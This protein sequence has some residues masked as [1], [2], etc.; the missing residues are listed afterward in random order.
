MKKLFKQITCFMLALL[1]FAGVAIAHPAPVK[2]A[3]DDDYINL[4]GLPL[5]LETST[6]GVARA[7][8][9]TTRST[10]PLYIDLYFAEP[11]SFSYE[12]KS[13][14]GTVVD[15]DTIIDTDEYW[16]SIT[17]ETTTTWV[18]EL[19]YKSAAVGTFSFD[20]T[21][22]TD[23]SY[24]LVIDQ[25][26][27]PAAT[28]SH[29]QMTITA[30]FTDKLKVENASGKVTWTSSNKSIA[31]VNDKGV[32]TAKK[33][34]RCT[35]TA[36]TEDGSKLKCV[37]KVA[38]NVYTRT[39][40]TNADADK[41]E[42]TAYIYKASTDASGNLVC[43]FR[44]IN[45]TSRSITKLSDMR[46]DVK[47]ANKKTLFSYKVKSKTVSVTGYRYKDYSI[48]IPKSVVKKCNL[49]T[50]TISFTGDYIYTL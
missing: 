44:V 31:T 39:K 35:V 20:V 19:P 24:A 17:G 6:A 5:T 12:L 2:A 27:T 3:E 40:G 28:I 32:V 22:M 48:T 36:T 14:S 42:V 33:K 18:Y 38:N 15:S 7:H 26:Q 13:A 23:T 30:G 34:G 8:S 9:F 21:T 43:K 41:N 45:N 10:G 1:L 50:A 37:I 11:T 47:N 4:Y 46:I 25:A 49:V 16:Q 29:S